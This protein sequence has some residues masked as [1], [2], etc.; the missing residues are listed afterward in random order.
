MLKRS[1]TKDTFLDKKLSTNQKCVM[2]KSRHNFFL[3]FP[4][5]FNL[6]TNRKWF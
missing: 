2:T 4:T 3:D 1:S 5:F 6:V